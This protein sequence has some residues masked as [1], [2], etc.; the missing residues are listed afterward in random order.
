M[1]HSLTHTL[2]ERQTQT[3]TLKTKEIKTCENDDKN[4]PSSPSRPVPVQRQRRRHPKLH[5]KPHYSRPSTHWAIRDESKGHCR[6]STISLVWQAQRATWQLSTPCQCQ[7]GRYKT[8]AK[9]THP[10]YQR[11]QGIRWPHRW[12]SIQNRQ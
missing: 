7:N 1:G 6:R 9:R 3:T 4:S 5:R 2:A 10:T 8:E 11:L 12:S